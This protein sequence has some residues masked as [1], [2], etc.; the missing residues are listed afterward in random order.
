MGYSFLHHHYNL[1]LD[2]MVEEKV[3]L[4]KLR[5]NFHFHHFHILQRKYL[6]LMK[7]RSFRTHL[8]GNLMRKVV[9]LA[10]KL[11]VNKLDFHHF[12]MFEFHDLSM[13]YCLEP[14]HNLLL[15]QR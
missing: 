10:L 2:K 5:D 7:Q 8:N 14:R 12:T 15:H 4:E 6:E 13:E 11:E 1:Q 3:D 9:L